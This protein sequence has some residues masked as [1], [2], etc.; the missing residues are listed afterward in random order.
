MCDSNSTRGS[1]IRFT[2]WN[3]KG[4]NGPNKRARIFAHLKKINTEIAFL[5]ETHLKIAD[6]MRLKKP[7]IGQV[8]HSHFNSKARG[9][10][11]LIH[12]KVQ[13][14]TSKCV[15]DPQGRFVIATGHLFHTPVALIKLFHFYPI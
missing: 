4:L 3:V 7:W 8:F 2:S 1:S 5:Q 13:F 10:A 14:Y 11:I 12:K 6:H 9:A 15:S